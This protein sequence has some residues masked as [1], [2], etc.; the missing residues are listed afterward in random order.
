MNADTWWQIAMFLAGT[1][2]GAQAH[3]LFTGAGRPLREMRAERDAMRAERD[4]ARAELDSTLTSAIND[5]ET[6]TQCVNS[7]VE[8]LREARDSRDR[9]EQDADRWQHYA[10]TLLIRI[11]EIEE[12]EAI[13]SKWGDA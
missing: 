3:Y 7:M 5:V 8:A 4:E 6:A 9:W 13:R 2:L 11:D 12:A 10:A 1:Y